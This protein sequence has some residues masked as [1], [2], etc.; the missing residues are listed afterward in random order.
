MI[1]GCNVAA[2]IAIAHKACLGEV[3]FYCGAAVLDS[4]D[5][6]RFVWQECVIFV[7][8]T[9]LATHVGSLAHSFRSSDGAYSLNLVRHPVLL[10]FAL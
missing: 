4:D 3:G 5:V 1:E 9:I 8:K 7:R 2:L 10:G 6:V